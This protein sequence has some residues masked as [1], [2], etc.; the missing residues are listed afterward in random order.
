MHAFGE[1]LMAPANG[2]E[3]CYQEMGDPEGEP[4]LLV[5]GLATQMI[6]WADEFCEML[7][8]RGFRVVRFDNRDI[9]R[10]TR[11]SSAGVP[12]KLDMVLGRRATAP[13][14]LR[15]MA[16]DTF[17]LMDHLGI[18]SAHLVGASM[19]GMIVQTAAIERPDRVRS[20]VSIMSTTGSRRVGHPSYRTFGLLLAKPPRHREAAVDRI[21]R[22]FRTI[23]SPGYPF[24]EERVREIAG[25][26]FDRGHSE[27]G[28]ARQLHAITASGDRTPRLEKLKIPTAVIHG[29]RDILV[30]PSGGRATAKAIPGARLK[31]VDG[32][33]HDLP[34]P[35]WPSF[36]EEIAANA[37]RAPEAAVA[38]TT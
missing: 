9:G 18:E 10:S 22:T 32:M 26:S 29:K 20:L 16:T 19:G 7:A 5:M 24:E 38:A 15:D 35:L 17:G 1:E 23:G 33:G 8:D 4:L 36:V 13:Y 37:A 12:G 6:A 34:R 30:N 3:L 28:I 11:L 2:I 25:R 31:M 14:L 27:A 21:V